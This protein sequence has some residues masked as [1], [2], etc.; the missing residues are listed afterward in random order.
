[1]T[2]WLWFCVA[3]WVFIGIFGGVVLNRNSLPS[4][5][6]VSKTKW[7][8]FVGHSVR[9]LLICCSKSVIVVKK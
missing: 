1:M 2:G 4:F 7:K 9:V 3:W 5:T 6:F 8:K